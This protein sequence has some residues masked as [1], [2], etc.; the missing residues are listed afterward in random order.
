MQFVSQDCRE[1]AVCEEWLCDEDV[2]VLRITL[3]CTCD[4]HESALIRSIASYMASFIGTQTP[5]S[6]KMCCIADSVLRIT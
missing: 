4:S 6:D 3:I 1:L 5:V 2:S